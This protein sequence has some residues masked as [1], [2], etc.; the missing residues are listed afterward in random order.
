MFELV[1]RWLRRRFVAL[2]GEG[3]I[4]QADVYHCQTCGR[5]RTWN[6]IR[7]PD[8]CCQGRL[9]PVNPTIWEKI[10]LLVLPWMV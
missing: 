4:N 2:H 3:E 10:K 6:H 5:L 7:K 1:E 8:M 9:V